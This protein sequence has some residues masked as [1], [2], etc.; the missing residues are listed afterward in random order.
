MGVPVTSLAA[1]GLTFTFLLSPSPSRIPGG[2]CDV[3]NNR[4]EVS[5]SVQKILGLHS[6]FHVFYELLD[7][8]P[9]GLRRIRPSLIC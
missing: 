1:G 2:G 5:L 9:G 3:F 7:V 8:G 4:I 6:R